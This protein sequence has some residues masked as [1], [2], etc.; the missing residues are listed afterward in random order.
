V[1]RGRVVAEGPLASVLGAQATR[2]R[3][4][5]LGPDGLAALA[6]F[7]PPTFDGRDVVFTELAAERVPDLVAALVG[8]GVRVHEVGSGRESL[9]QRFLQLVG[10][11]TDG[12]A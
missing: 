7:G 6:A 1:D 4:D 8:M 11:N 12:A 2:I 5:G 3:V 9:E 10:Q